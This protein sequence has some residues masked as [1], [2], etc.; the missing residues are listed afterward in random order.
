MSTEE[1]QLVAQA[2][3]E[4][5]HIQDFLWDGCRADPK[6]FD[7]DG[8]RALFQKRVDSISTVDLSRPGGLVLLRKRLLQQAAL[9][10]HALT[11][12]NRT[13]KEGN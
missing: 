2:I 11:I 8:W 4:A 6:T 9:S 5:R 1:L 3:I 12:V 7:A 13:Y 10:I